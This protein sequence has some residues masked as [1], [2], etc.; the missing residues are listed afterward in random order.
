ML[1]L[2]CECTCMRVCGGEGVCGLHIHVYIASCIFL[3]VSLLLYVHVCVHIWCVQTAYLYNS[4]NT[5]SQAYLNLVRMMIQHS[6]KDS[7]C[8][9]RNS[10]AFPE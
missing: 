8:D 5:P 6:A 10:K 1:L 9:K 4:S 3:E 2:E 7:C